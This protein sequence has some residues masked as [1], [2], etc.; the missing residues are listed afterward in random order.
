MQPSVEDLFLRYRRGDTR[1]LAA[2]FDRT[3]P[4]LWRVA[5]CL[6]RDRGAA[7]DLLQ[8]TYLAAMQSAAR[9]RDDQP[10]MPWLVGILANH[11]RMAARRQRREVPAA[12]VVPRE[13]ED[14]AVAAEQGELRQLLRARIDELPETY[15]AVLVLQLEHGMTA[16]EVAHALGRPR[17]TVR[18]QLH[19]GLEMLRR[20]LPAALAVYAG[21]AES[22]PD[23]G[24]VRGALMAAAGVST[25]VV[26]TAVGVG[27]MAMKKLMAVVVVV[28]AVGVYWAWPGGAPAPQ[29]APAP[30]APGA[31][32]SAAVH[33]ATAAAGGATAA[34]R[35]EVK[36][37]ADPGGA[38]VLVVHVHWADGAPAA[39]TTISAQP[40]PDDDW[41]AQR[42]AAT[43]ARGVATFADFA[44]G[45]VRVRARHGGEVEALV[46]AGKT[47]AVDLTIPAGIDARGTVVDPDGNLVA[48]A[49]VV[50]GGRIEDM[51]EAAR[52][53]GSGAFSLRALAAKTRV[54]AFADGFAGSQ[55]VT[56]ADFADGPLQLRLRGA[57]A[58]VC[59]RV[60]DAEGAPLAGA[61]V[62]AGHA[63]SMFAYGEKPTLGS[64]HVVRTDA[65]GNFRLHG[66]PFGQPFPLH[67]GAKGH[68]SWRGQVNVARGETPFVEVRLARAVQLRGVVRDQAGAPM[69]R[70]YVGVTD[71]NSPGKLIGDARPSW[72]RTSV[73]TAADG[74]YAFFSLAP[75]PLG[76]E[77]HNRRSRGE[78]WAV[79]WQSFT[80][81][82][83]EC[84]QWD[85]VLRADLAIRGTLV[86]EAGRPLA[87]W[88]LVV[89]AA[90]GVPQPGEATSGDDGSF[91]LVGC[92]PATY[93][94]RCYAPGDQWYAAV[95]EQKGVVPGGEP[96]RLRV[97]RDRLP[98][99]Y[100]SGSL[101]AD[102]PADQWMLVVLDNGRGSQVR[103]LQPG[104]RFELGPL[105]P[106]NYALQLQAQASGRAGMP[107]VVPVGDRLLQPGQRVDL[108][109]LRLPVLGQLAVELDDAAGQPV[110]KTSLRFA[111]LGAPQGGASV[112]IAAGRGS[113]AVAPGSYL[114]AGVGGDGV[115]EHGP[116]E[117]RGG[118]CTTVHLRLVT[119]VVRQ[120]RYD[121][122]AVGLPARC[123]ATFKKDGAPLQRKWFSFWQ[124]GPSTQDHRFTPGFW[125]LELELGDGRVQRFPFVVTAD[126]EAPPIDIRVLP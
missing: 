70:A 89:D 112:A 50:I 69:A 39:A 18:S 94:V 110:A 125:E 61:W 40:L 38:T 87:G 103:Q 6:V 22:V 27:V 62:T 99:C 24:R 72:N 74:S 71:A 80:A 58:D 77:V 121:L 17:A 73:E 83:G 107:L 20:T 42:L 28:L 79:A 54:A 116:I 35:V 60:F 64:L 53:D 75:G 21:H 16:A 101:A 108:G 104:T 84:L 86:D 91:A 66:I 37:P 34:E 98:S 67:A 102:Q 47:T 76:V 36:M 32:V 10:L 13:V 56:A 95:A 29:P 82:P 65:G 85:P 25:A 59:G 12:A 9:W 14:P 122:T 8:A 97:G 81:G 30:A 120:L 105:P 126:A 117:V 2:V 123:F 114:P 51:L 45:K 48:G 7:D 96:L 100:L 33:G 19:R 43:D 68:A 23:L 5:R 106:G 90:E 118:E 115:V 46:V 55:T 4:E 49:V 26:G 113:V 119:G 11:V 52:T 63:V 78:A 124:E 88:R 15:R 1:A 109:E 44:A 57:A 111:M 3:A 31:A 92:A 41:F 93:T